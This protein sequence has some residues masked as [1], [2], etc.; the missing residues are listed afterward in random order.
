MLQDLSYVIPNVFGSSFRLEWHQKD[1]AKWETLSEDI[2]KSQKDYE[3]SKDGFWRK[4]WYD[5]GDA[6]DAIDP[7]FALIPNDYGLAVVKTGVAVLF[8][9]CLTPAGT[10]LTNATDDKLP[11]RYLLTGVYLRSAD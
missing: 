9:V 1:P 11:A 7:W 5:I 8:K 10:Y 3:S 2:M 4:I 6:K